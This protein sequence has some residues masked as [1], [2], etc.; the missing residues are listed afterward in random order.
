MEKNPKQTKNQNLHKTTLSKLKLM[1]YYCVL[2]PNKGIAAKDD[3]PVLFH[4]NTVLQKEY[5]NKDGEMSKSKVS[6]VQS[7]AEENNGQVKRA[8]KAIKYIK[9]KSKH[10]PK[11]AY[12][13]GEIERRLI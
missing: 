6:A 11:L 3:L 9:K 10:V 5:K 4:K 8:D 12:I 7:L 13:L 2:I 1:N